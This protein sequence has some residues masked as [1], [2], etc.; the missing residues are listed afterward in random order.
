[1]QEL[2]LEAYRFALEHT[3]DSVVITDMDSIIQYVNPAFTTITG[4]T[5]EEAVG[6]K[7]NI[8]AS[9]QTTRK[10]YEGMWGVILAGGWWRGEVVN[11]KKSGEEWYSFLTISQVKD[12]SGVPSGYVGVARDITEMKQLQFRLK[13]ASLEAIFMLCVACEAKDMTTGNHL[14]RVRHY[15][16]ALALR[17][18]LSEA[19]AEELDYSSMMHDLGKLHVP[20]AVLKKAG[21]LTQEEWTEMV[22]HPNGGAIILR[23]K[24]FYAVAREIAAS[25]HENWDGSGYPE[26]KKGADIPLSA[27]IVKVADVFDALT[28]RRPYKEPWSDDDAIHELMAKKG[29]AFDPKVVDAFIAMNDEGLVAKIRAD[30]PQEVAK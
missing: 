26:G 20:D 21:P 23:N 30:F 15:T 4:F 28:S 1:M 12:A 17:L 11:I 16:H 3:V 18:G 22:K 6:Q 13:E 29:K 5:S 27:R 24:P 9:P 25:H 8:I 10:T 19:E 7:P 14:Q 2:P